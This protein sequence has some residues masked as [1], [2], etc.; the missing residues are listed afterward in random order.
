MRIAAVVNP[1]K[2]SD[3]T[4]ARARMSRWVQEHHGHGATLAWY[5]TTRADPGTQRARE[6]LAAEPDLVLVWGGD[7]TVTAVAAAMAAQ[8]ADRAR[9]PLGLLPGGT[10]NLL[11]RNLGLPR[12]LDGAAAA[13]LGGVDRAIDVIDVGLGGQTAMSTVIA[14]MGLDSVLIDAPEGLKATLGPAAY[15]MQS[16]RL[17]AHRR[18]RV[19]VSVDGSPPR[20]SWARCVLVANVGGLVAGLDAVPEASIDDGF[21]DV[22]V[23]T[24]STPRDWAVAAASLVRRRQRDAHGRF[25]L[26]GRRAVVV[27]RGDQRRQIDGDVL[28]DGDRLEA[29]V[30]PGALVVRVSR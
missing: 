3:P 25:H 7:G 29:R 19:G 15:A 13:A 27:A 24:M 22:V 16:V 11:A 21:L 23:L 5:E 2:V 18:M 4:D 8:A 9:V 17:V 20:W 12:D 10:G 14:G 1:T 28:A 26:R 30:R 6:A